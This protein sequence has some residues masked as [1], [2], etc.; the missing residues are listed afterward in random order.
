VG[1]VATKLA[2]PLADVSAAVKPHVDIVGVEVVLEDSVA[3]IR[4]LK[5]SKLLAQPAVRPLL[6]L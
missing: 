1:L 3:A 5:Q 2:V 6:L 4:L